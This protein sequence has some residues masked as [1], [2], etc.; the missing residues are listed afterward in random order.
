MF[1]LLLYFITDIITFSLPQET[2]VTGFET[3]NCSIQGSSLEIFHLKTF[4]VEVTAIPKLHFSLL[5]VVSIVVTTPWDDGICST[6]LLDRMLP[7]FFNM[8]LWKGPKQASIAKSFWTWTKV[9]H[10]SCLPSSNRLPLFE[11]VTNDSPFSQII[12]EHLGPH[13][14]LQCTL[15]PF[16]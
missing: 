9:R 7:S 16:S 11:P 14:S 5:Q 13:L 4:F 10:W 3:G 2:L 6:F 8:T 12:A 1:F 15:K